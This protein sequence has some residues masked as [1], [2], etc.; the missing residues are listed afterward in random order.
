MADEAR[1]VSQLDDCPRRC[2]RV[3][4]LPEGPHRGEQGAEPLLVRADG[5][6]ASSAEARSPLSRGAGREVIRVAKTLRQT[7]TMAWPWSAPLARHRR[8]A[9]EPKQ[10]QRRA[11]YVGQ[12]PHLHVLGGHDVHIVQDVRAHRDVILALTHHPMRGSETKRP[13][14]SRS[15]REDTKGRETSRL[16]EARS[17]PWR[18]L[19]V[20]GL[21]GRSAVDLYGPL[22][23]AT[24]P[25]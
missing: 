24:T 10:L 18:A 13:G 6:R 23:T 21:V 20:G 1:T 3:G 11:R 9:A 5:V 7:S 16:P 15:R 22:P 19:S 2:A 4:R 14:R 8:S 25:G 12:A 17:L